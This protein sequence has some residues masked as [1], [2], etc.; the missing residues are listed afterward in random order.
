MRFKILVLV[1]L[2]PI[3]SFGQIINET[4][5]QATTSATT[6]GTGMP[7]NYSVGNYVLSSGV[8]TLNDAISN[9]FAGN[10]NSIPRYI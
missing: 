3:F 4:F 5:N 1:L 6:G 10:Q 7:A 8:W 2:F 9:T